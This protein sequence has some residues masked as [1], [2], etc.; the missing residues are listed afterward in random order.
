M[1]I[2]ASEQNN[3]VCTY[4]HIHTHTFIYLCIKPKQI[5]KNKQTTTENGAEGIHTLFGRKRVFLTE[6]GQK[7]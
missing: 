2:L 1:H 7:I 3:S 4:K 6:S 5:L